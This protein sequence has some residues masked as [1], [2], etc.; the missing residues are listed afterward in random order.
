VTEAKIPFPREGE[1]SPQ[2]RGYID[3]VR[4]VADVRALLRSQPETLRAALQPLSEEQALARYAP[5]KWSIKEMVGHVAD[6]ERIFAYRL[7]RIARGDETPLPGFDQDLYV[8]AS[9]FDR[10]PL[11]TV[12]AEFETARAATLALLDG[13]DEEALGRRG[14]ASNHPVTAGALVH[15]IAGHVQ[16]HLRV[17]R[18]KYGVGA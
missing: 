2:A 14:V 13:L 18:E 1:Y 5:G 4:D 7:L 16:H 3:A 8:A 15:I 11:A 9:A 12:L 17:L 6:T 10:R